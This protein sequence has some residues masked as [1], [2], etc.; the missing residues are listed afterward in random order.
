MLQ[1]KVMEGLDSREWD[2]FVETSNNGTLF[3][4]L[5]F[6]T[7][8]PQGRFS[9]YNLAFSKKDNL[10]AVLPGALSESIFKSPAGAT[11]GS[12]ATKDLSYLQYEELIDTF[13]AFM[14]QNGCR[15]IQLT[16]PMLPYMETQ[17]ELEKFV[18]SYRGFQPTQHLISSVVSLGDL[19]T[20]EDIMPALAQRF[21]GDVKKS[22]EA[23]LEIV[24]CD[25]FE[26]FYPILVDNK[27]KLQATPTHSY[28]ELCA[29]KKLFPDAI[30]LIMAY[31][32][33]GG[34]PVAGM[35]FFLCNPRTALAFYI[36]HYYEFRD[37]KAVSRL[38]Y[39]T[40]VWLKSHGYEYFDLGVSM[41]TL[42][43]NPMEPSRNLIFF[44]EALGSKSFV[45]TTYQLD[46]EKNVSLKG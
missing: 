10:V 39:E 14:K 8:H 29:L 33:D 17:N 27:K 5:K 4:K 11:F 23:G 37:Y 25:D 1:V 43:Q 19:K 3:H 44:K 32:S 40:L 13:L 22:N 15:R 28:E 24:F 30:K 6:L 35:V 16:P 21:R 2:S 26:N 18:L 31:T 41:D 7:Y 38:L 46:L 12:F 36:S 9:F 45:R 42:S 34:K 20:K